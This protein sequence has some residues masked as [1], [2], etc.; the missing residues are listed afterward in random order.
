MI[1][2]MFRLGVSRR[3]TTKLTYSKFDTDIKYRIEIIEM[4]K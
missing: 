2:P 1:Q 3:V 4:G